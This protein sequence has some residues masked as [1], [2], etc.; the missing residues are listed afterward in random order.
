MRKETGIAV[1]ALPTALP[2]PRFG[3]TLLTGTI[4]ALFQSVIGA[5]GTDAAPLLP[6]TGYWPV[7]MLTG[8]VLGSGV[9]FAVQG[10]GRLWNRPLLE[11]ALVSAL[12]C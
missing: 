3:R 6:R 12:I 8:P 10:W 2:A 5:V 1:H 9:A 7:V 4:A 11:G